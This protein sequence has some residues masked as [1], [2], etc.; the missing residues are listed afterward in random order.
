MNEISFWSSRF[1]ELLNRRSASGDAQPA[2]RRPEKVLSSNLQ[3]FC[4]AAGNSVKWRR[5]WTRFEIQAATVSQRS[6]GDARTCIIISTKSESLL[7]A[8]AW[9]VEE[10][11]RHLARI[12]VCR[13]C[14]CKRKLEHGHD[15]HPPGWWSRQ[16]S[17]L[18]RLASDPRNQFTNR[19]NPSAKAVFGS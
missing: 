9:I 12:I 10:N 3:A 7:E 11:S 1:T 16:L 5:K 13:P 4:D 14:N 2:T 6:S 15:S 17:H 18:A 19:G 8:D